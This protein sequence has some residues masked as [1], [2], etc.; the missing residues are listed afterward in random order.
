[1]WNGFKDN[2]FKNQFV[3]M[4]TTVC[5]SLFFEAMSEIDIFHTW[6]RVQLVQWLMMS[7][8][9]S[10]AQTT[11]IAFFT[12]FIPAIN[13]RRG[14][15]GF[16]ILTQRLA[17]RSTTAASLLLAQD[18]FIV[19]IPTMQ[20]LIGTREAFI[21]RSRTGTLDHV[22]ASRFFLVEFRRLC[23]KDLLVWNRRM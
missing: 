18:P 4:V 9:E 12:L 19:P 2:L 7:F 21:T 23:R 13:P 3:G 14:A 11:V 17:R 20:G 22:Q 10:R 1:M 16:G 5:S 8:T 15:N 6:Y